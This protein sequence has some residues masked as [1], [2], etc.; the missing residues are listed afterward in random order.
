[1]IIKPTNFPSPFEYYSKE[2]NITPERLE[3]AYRTGY[4][5]RQYDLEELIEYIQIL[6]GTKLDKRI[7]KRF[8]RHA[9]MNEFMLT[10]QKK[11]IKEYDTDGLEDQSYIR[12][13]VK[14]KI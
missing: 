1:M 6:S 7:V 5:W 11:G 2:Y 10:L 14:D 13:L 4:L 9:D 3:K 12:R 8:I